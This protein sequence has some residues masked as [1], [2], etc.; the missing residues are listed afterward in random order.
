M[1]WH[2]FAL[3]CFLTLAEKS[4]DLDTYQQ[5]RLYVTRRAAQA[6]AQCISWDFQSSQCFVYVFQIMGAAAIRVRIRAAQH[7]VESQSSRPAV[8]PVAEAWRRCRLVAHTGQGVA[9]WNLDPPSLFLHGGGGRDEQRQSLPCFQRRSAARSLPRRKRHGRREEGCAPESLPPLTYV[10]CVPL[11][12]D[13]GT[14]VFPGSFI[15][16][17]D[18]LTGRATFFAAAPRA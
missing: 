16:H 4:L 9:A 3:L 2:A 17:D 6:S 14:G 13:H 8:P 1:P 5:P 7:R 10:V 15:Q 18:G 11:P 12:I